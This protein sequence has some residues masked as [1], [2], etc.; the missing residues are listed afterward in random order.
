MS[1]LPLPC[2]TGVKSK[3]AA[4]KTGGYQ[5]NIAMK[6]PIR[7]TVETTLPPSQHAMI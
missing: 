6:Q 2:T 7:K 3:N 1:I 5:E 4:G